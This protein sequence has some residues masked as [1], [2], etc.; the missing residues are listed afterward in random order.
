M[1]TLCTGWC[2]LPQRLSVSVVLLLLPASAAH[3][4]SLRALSLRAPGRTPAKPLLRVSPEDDDGYDAQ[5][6]S[7]PDLKDDYDAGLAFGK[8]IRRRFAA[9]RIDD[10]GLPYADSLVCICGT[11]FVAMIAVK[12]VIPLPTWLEPL[13]GTAL[14]GTRGLPYIFPAFRHGSALAACWLLGALAASAF[15]REAYSASLREAVS[16]TWRGGAFATGMLILATQ[17]VTYSTLSGQGIDPY[18]PSIEADRALLT[19]AFE[20]ITDIAV[21]A[22]GLTAFRVYRW[23]DARQYGER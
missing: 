7:A 2:V 22:V 20:V 16:R 13:P 19:T 5:L 1:P 17:L 12:G 10:P 6:P 23:V 3:V 18:L 8:D 15:E 21:Q 4:G 14:P 9:P 11:L